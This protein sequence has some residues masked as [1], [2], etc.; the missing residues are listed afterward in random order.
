MSKF[1]PLR[2]VVL[3]I[4]NTFPLSRL[5]CSEDVHESVASTQLSVFVVAPSTEMPAPSAV[6][7]SGLA[8][9][10]RTMFL[11]STVIVAVLSVV[12]LP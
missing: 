12:V 6:V 10:A 4:L 1:V 11:S 5:K 7:S 8:T 3:L 9:L 2:T